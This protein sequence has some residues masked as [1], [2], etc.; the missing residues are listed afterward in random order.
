MSL[1]DLAAAART[2][3]DAWA[4]SATLEHEL[5]IARLDVQQLAAANSQLSVKVGGGGGSHDCN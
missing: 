5:A 3:A 4:G 2:A 1:I